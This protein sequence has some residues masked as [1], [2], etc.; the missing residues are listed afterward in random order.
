MSPVS[1]PWSQNSFAVAF[2]RTYVSDC[3]IPLG[4]RLLQGR[5]YIFVSSTC[6]FLFN[7]LRI[8]PLVLWS[9]SRAPFHVFHTAGH[10]S[11]TSR[12][13]ILI[14]Q[15]HILSC[16]TSHGIYLHQDFTYTWSIHIHL[17]KTLCAILF[18]CGWFFTIFCCYYTQS[19][20][21]SRLLSNATFP[22]DLHHCLSSLPYYFNFDKISFYLRQFAYLPS[23]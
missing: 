10:Q 21:L 19:S 11:K 12:L 18:R 7:F 13:P 4:F 8:R 17:N 1:H 16:Q 15:R 9:K 23:L 14:I 3:F 22:I 6:L 5:K 2:S 20:T